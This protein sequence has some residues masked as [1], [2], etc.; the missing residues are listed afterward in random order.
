MGV[1]DNVTKLVTNKGENY[2]GDMYFGKPEAE[3]ENVKGQGLL[4]FFD[5]YL[6]IFNEMKVGKFLF[7]GRKGT[8]KSAIAKYIKDESDKSDDSYACILRMSDI[9]IEKVVQQDDKENEYALIEWLL[10]LNLTKLI[11]KSG[12]AKYTTEFEKLAKFLERNTGSVDVD[13]KEIVERLSSKNGEVNFEILRHC[14]G[15]IIRRS[16]QNKE[17][18]APFY[19]MITP[20]KEILKWLFQTEDVK[21]REFWILVDDLDVGYKLENE[22]DNDKLMD[23]IRIVRVYNT[24]LLG[25]NSRILVFIREDIC[26]NIVNKYNDS[27]KII[28]SNIIPINWYVPSTEMGNEDTVPLKKLADKRIGIAFEKKGLSVSHEKSPWDCLINK[29]YQYN[30]GSSFKSILDFTFY[31]PRDIVTFLDAVRMGNYSMPLSI[32]NVKRALK[33]YIELSI[34]ELKSELS[35]SFSDEEKLVL[36]NDVFPYIINNDLSLP[37]F[38]EYIDTKGFEKSTNTVVDIL[39]EYALIGL[40]DGR[41]YYFNFREHSIPEG[42][43]INTYSIIVPKCILYHYRDISYI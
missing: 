30:N 39:L 32:T 12:S 41:K 37:Q 2:T 26:K 43:D 7:V 31:R 3:S 13:Q 8:G 40:K 38:K 16:F 17:Q 10:L 34:N 27:A 5:D 1:L 24:E 29:K 35:L 11:V 23:L 25:D 20:L 6:G 36:F 9:T 22:L 19:K 14:F 18:T 4:D 42:T 33:K 21:S 15:G 28:Q